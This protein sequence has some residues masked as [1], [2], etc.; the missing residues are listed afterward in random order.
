MRRFVKGIIA[1]PEFSFNKGNHY[2][3]KTEFKKGQK[4]WNKNLTSENDKRVKKYV[5]TRKKNY[6]Q[7]KF[8][9]WNDGLTKETDERVRKNAENIPTKFRVGHL[10]PTEWKEAIYKNNKG[11][12]LS[13]NTEFKRGD[14]N[15]QIMK[16]AKKLSIKPTKPEKIMIKIIEKNN[17]PFNYVGN[18]KIWIGGFNP[19]FLSKNPKHII[20]VFGDYWHNKPKVK[21]RDGRRIEAYKKLGYVPLVIWEHELR[22]PK[23][24]I[25]KIENLIK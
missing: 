1:Y 13:P 11:K 25:N 20:E 9:N 4:P 24:I 19:D 8:K 7:G 21:E 2:S 10:V 23:E 16:A 22:N 14:L 5:Q 3:Q 15:N 6:S 17:L 18:G 12:H